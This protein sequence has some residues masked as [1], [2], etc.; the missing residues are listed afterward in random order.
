MG[1]SGGGA[2]GKGEFGEQAAVV[3]TPEGMRMVWELEGALDVEMGDD[4]RM[5]TDGGASGS[6]SGA[7]AVEERLRE[8]VPPDAV[9]IMGGDVLVNGQGPVDAQVGE[10]RK[11][12]GTPTPSSRPSKRIRLASSTPAPA[13]APAPSPP[14]SLLPPP[15]PTDRLDL[16]WSAQRSDLLLANSLPPLPSTSSSSPFPHSSSQPPTYAQITSS[17]APEHPRKR[18][19]KPKPTL[20]S[21]PPARG[22]LGHM[23]ANI[24]TLHRVRSTHARFSVLA[25]AASA[26]S[27][28]PDDPSAPSQPSLSSALEAEAAAIL[29]GG[30]VVEDVDEIDE[31]PWAVPTR[32]VS[33]S[34]P[35]STSTTSTSFPPETREISGEDGKPRK[36]LVRRKERR[37]GLE[38][39]NE[40]ADGCMHWMNRKVLEHEGFQGSSKV[41]LDVLSGIASEFLMGV[42]RT[43]RFYLDRYSG[44]MTSEV[45]RSF[46]FS[47]LSEWD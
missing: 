2:G 44:S 43:M 42:G 19:R 29:A 6:G 26:S 18:R 45:C 47:S 28:N 17:T 31:R 21:Q 23:N 4:V 33:A 16:W 38:I 24:K 34:F 32:P 11:S 36:V 25:A 10:K 40:D 1:R 30:P 37:R 39:G 3:R 41:A 12:T 14:P 27:N 9:S 46:S 5:D 22:L 15:P 13:P 7:V 35:A 8:L 20:P